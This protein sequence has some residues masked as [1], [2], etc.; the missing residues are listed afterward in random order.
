MGLLVIVGVLYV[1]PVF[2]AARTAES[3]GYRRSTGVLLGLVLSW[4]GALIV[5]L[6]PYVPADR[7]KQGAGMAGTV[8]C[9]N[10]HPNPLR[11]SRCQ[12]CG[13][14]GGWKRIA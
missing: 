5:A 10:G 6:M 13:A 14:R 4:L 9:Q 1:A 2:I 7:V 3:K 8:L 12:V 11:S